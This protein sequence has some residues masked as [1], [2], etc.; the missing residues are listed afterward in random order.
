MPKIFIIEKKKKRKK[1]TADSPNARNKCR[2]KSNVNLNTVWK[3]DFSNEFHNVN[4]S[5][6][7]N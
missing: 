7:E 5:I 2:L 1:S 6:R 4:S 3:F